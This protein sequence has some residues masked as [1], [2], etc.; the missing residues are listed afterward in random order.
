MKT[1]APDHVETTNQVKTP[2]ANYHSLYNTRRWRAASKAFLS[3]H[4]FCKCG[5]FAEATDH[6]IPHRGDLKLFW[7]R[8]NWQTLCKRCHDRKTGRGQ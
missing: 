2:A 5:Q 8:A 6:I 1:F 3:V 4:P 7:D